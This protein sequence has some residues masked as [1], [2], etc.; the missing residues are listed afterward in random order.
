M[1]DKSLHVLLVEDYQP[2][3][4]MLR[5]MLL[6]A[7]ASN[8]V[9]EVAGT[10]N[11]A[12]KRIT[13]RAP[14]IVLL[15]LQLPDS[16]GIDTFAS[17]FAAGDFPIVVLS[18]VDDEALAIQTVKQGA[19]D[20]LVKGRVDHN[21]VV[22]TVRYA[23]ERARIQRE[24]EAARVEL[25][26]RVEERTAEF[27][28]ANDKLRVEVEQRQKAEA[29]VRGTN[30]Q[31]ADALELLRKTQEQVVQRERLHA[32]GQMA[33]GIA[34]EFNNALAPII[35]FSDM[36][37]KKKS[38]GD[39][40]E[41]SREYLKMINTAAKDSAKIVGHL[42]EF[43]RITPD[44]AGM[45]P[46]SLNSIAGQAITL[47]QPFWKDQAQS[48]GANIVIRSELDP[49]T[50][51]INGDEVALRE[52][53]TNLVVNSID[54]VGQG[55]V[56]TISTSHENGRVLLK[57]ADDGAGMDRATV[58]HCLE[59]FFTTKAEHGTGLGLSITYGIVQRHGGS[60]DIQSETGRGTVITASFPLQS[61]A[62]SVESK[63]IT[64][65]KMKPS[66]ILVVEDEPLVKELIGVYLHEDNHDV[67]TAS[68][69]RE[70]LDKFRAGEFDLVLTDRAM[71]GMNGEQLARMIK[72]IKPSQPIILLTGFGD[73]LPGEKLP[74]G[75]DD[76][77][78]KPFTMQVLREAIAKHLPQ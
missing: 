73:L 65:L 71:P 77:V 38:L 51:E 16:T 76:I 6:R 2:H 26:R 49:G 36:L 37:L 42:R 1:S 19:Q 31:L 15:D 64:K 57:V 24:L 48:R 23:M 17:V 9:V 54:A 13:S 59:P 56:I 11:E 8:W 75:I 34:H 29:A 33:S 21:V 58:E 70:G 10:L 45:Q 55:G 46:V 40:P 22:R 28:E 44:G 7:G 66:R 74:E 63:K 20:Y 25:E 30:D 18:G 78:G 67:Q 32:L 47:T 50:P 39:D 72:E 3:V 68:D 60:L 35:G 12:L 62:A 41:K 43:Y 14:D 27:K 4:V 5:E 53:I 61:G 52:M 69:G